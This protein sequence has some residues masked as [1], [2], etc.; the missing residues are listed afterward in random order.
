MT[1][2]FLNV[3]SSLIEAQ[4]ANKTFLD[5]AERFFNVH[6]ANSSSPITKTVSAVRRKS[7]SVSI[8]VYLYV[9]HV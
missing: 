3:P 9:V 7:T 1:A 4:K 5:F 2:T 6:V 8:N